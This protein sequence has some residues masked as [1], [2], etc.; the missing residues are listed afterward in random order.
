MTLDEW[1]H[2]FEH[3]VPA[4]SA[5]ATLDTWSHVNN[6]NRAFP[7]SVWQDLPANRQHLQSR[8]SLDE[9][10]PGREITYP[11]LLRPNFVP[12]IIYG[13]SEFASP[14]SIKCYVALPPLSQIQRLLAMCFAKSERRIFFVYAPKSEQFYL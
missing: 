6:D 4:H 13:L 7:R 8:A 11:V 5:L 9:D 1:V 14:P 2:T 10:K 3:P 12:Y